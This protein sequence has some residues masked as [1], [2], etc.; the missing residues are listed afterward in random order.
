MK[1]IGLLLFGLWLAWPM[2][3]LAQAVNRAGLVVV[4]GDG[5]T[6]ARCVGF[7]EA[8]ISGYE[9]LQQSGL[10]LRVEASGMGPTVCSL[11]Q[12]GC[13]AGSSC[14]CQCQSSPCVYWSYWRQGASGPA[15]PAPPQWTYSSSGAGGTQVEAGMV[16][17]WVWSEGIVGREADMQP[18]PFTF[19][20]IC[21]ADAVVYGLED[22][23]Y[24]NSMALTTPL[25]VGL[26]LGV[27]LLAI[28]I[29][30]FLV[31]KRSIV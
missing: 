4:H 21:T 29:W 11:D 23:A 28:A 8:S 24:A 25:M 15:T 7:P 10:E 13:G 27:P 16:E 2:P 30:W 12:E 18:P 6:E 5:S 17:G 26:V 19:A 1:A 20:E 3:A 22:V 31:R 9:L 14:F